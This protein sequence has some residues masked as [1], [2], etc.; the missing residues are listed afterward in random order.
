MGADAV[1][2][3]VP[4]ASASAVSLAQYESGNGLIPVLEITKLDDFPEYYSLKGV[5]QY[6]SDQDFQNVK[7][8]DLV[9]E[10]PMFYAPVAQWE[11]AH[12]ELYSKNP[13]ETKSFV[14]FELYAVNGSTVVSLADNGST[15]FASH[16]LAVTPLPAK[17]VVE[18]SYKVIGDVDVE[19]TPTNPE[20]VYNP[21]TF[22]APVTVETGSQV[23]LQIVSASGKVYGQDPTNEK[24]LVENGEPFVITQVGPLL[25]TV[26]MEAMTYEVTSAIPEIFAYGT[27][28]SGGYA[29]QTTDFV[30]Y[31]GFAG[32]NQGYFRLAD[33]KK[34]P[35]LKWGQAMEGPE[36]LEEEVPG[37]IMLSSNPTSVKVPEKG[38]YFLEVNLSSLT[39]SASYCEHFS[40][41]GGWDGWTQ[42]ILLT[43]TDK[44]FMVWKGEITITNGTNFKIRTN[45]N[46]EGP[47][48]GI[49]N[50]STVEG[51]YELQEHGAD[52]TW[53]LGDGTFAVTLDLSKVPYTLKAVLK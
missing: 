52:I 9:Y 17:I 34:N 3:T 11:S 6:A 42:D 13:R 1:S 8:I 2:V 49:A 26:N 28:T 35:K 16:P 30:N 27:S 18:E 20:D 33:A 15:L 45:S 19:M 7:N 44:Y 29:L 4:D 22:S 47:D 36:G 50:G 40:L 51:Y 48:L 53:N 32:L 5:M 41:I 37:K 12:V 38:C 43:T 39:Y 24:G 21:P 25:L 14:R 31:R 10:E 23:S 46:W